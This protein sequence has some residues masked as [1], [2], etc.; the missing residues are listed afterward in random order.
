MTGAKIAEESDA[1]LDSLN[2]EICITKDIS[3][4]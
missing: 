1:R 4:F 2:N 3:T